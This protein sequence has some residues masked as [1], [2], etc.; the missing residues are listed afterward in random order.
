MS[1]ILQLQREV[2]A[3]QLLSAMLE[4]GDDVSQSLLDTILGAIVP[5]KREE[6]P[7]AAAFARE[8]IQANQATLASH[9]QRLL[10]CMMASN[11]ADTA[12]ECSYRTLLL[13]VW[14]PL[15]MIA[16]CRVTRNLVEMAV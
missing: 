10:A 13:E 15:L 2:V 11:T 3:V 12:L 5:P 1:V 6:N 16:A 7:E 14:S 8:L 9:I 4:E